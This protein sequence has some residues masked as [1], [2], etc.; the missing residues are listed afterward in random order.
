[1]SYNLNASYFKLIIS[2]IALYLTIAIYGYFSRRSLIIGSSSSKL[3]YQTFLILGT[4]VDFS[5]FNGG[6][7][8]GSLT[9]EVPPPIS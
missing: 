3:S 6:T 2:K 4:S 1:M 7:N 5:S 9:N 8:E